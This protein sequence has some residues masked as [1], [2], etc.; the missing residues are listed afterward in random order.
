ML[1]QG[2]QR[3]QRRK[4]LMFQGCGGFHAPVADPPK[5]EH[6]HHRKHENQEHDQQDVPERCPERPD[7]LFA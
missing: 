7:V 2:R 6:L 4:T 5:Y 3:I 1:L